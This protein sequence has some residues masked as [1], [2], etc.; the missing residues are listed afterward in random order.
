[1]K[2]YDKAIC[3]KYYV[4]L[5]IQGMQTQFHQKLVSYKC[6]PFVDCLTVIVKSVNRVRATIV[7]KFQFFSLEGLSS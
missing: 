2:N 4:Q 7:T 6:M 1:M 3:C 5:M